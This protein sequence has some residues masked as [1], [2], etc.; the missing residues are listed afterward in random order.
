M[1]EARKKNKMGSFMERHP[2]VCV[3]ELEEEEAKNIDAVRKT[4]LW[5]CFHVQCAARQVYPVSRRCHILLN[6]MAFCGIFQ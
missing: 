6:A 3:P 1:A 5:Q 4:D 2:L